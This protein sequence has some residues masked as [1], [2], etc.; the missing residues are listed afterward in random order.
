[1]KA[2]RR[3]Y[4]MI[5]RITGK[6]KPYTTKHH[7]ATGERKVKDLQLFITNAKESVYDEK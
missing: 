6:R 5:P 1:M 2:T 7:T 4:K 3:I